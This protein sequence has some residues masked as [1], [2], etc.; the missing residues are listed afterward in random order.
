MAWARGGSIPKGYQL[1]P[2]GI[3]ASS[4]RAWSRASRS[5]VTQFVVDIGY[6]PPS[7]M[8]AGLGRRWWPHAGKRS[9]KVLISG[10]DA[11]PGQHIHGSCQ[12]TDFDTLI[13]LSFDGRPEPPSE[14]VSVGG[15]AA[16]SSRRL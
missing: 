15:R 7:A 11:P 1:P 6:D 13:E 16:L 10:L 5:P 3:R 8:A 4:L 9:K 2:S 14:A 12:R